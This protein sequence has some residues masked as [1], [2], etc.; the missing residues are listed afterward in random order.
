MSSL[1]QFVLFERWEQHASRERERESSEGF[2]EDQG[3]IVLSR[4]NWR[5]F[6]FHDKTVAAETRALDS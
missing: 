1:N 5:R 4:N 6:F 3:D 2:G